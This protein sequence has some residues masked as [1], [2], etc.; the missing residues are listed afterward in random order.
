MRIVDVATFKTLPAGTVFTSYNPDTLLGT[1]R[2]LEIKQ[3]SPESSMISSCSIT[4]IESLDSEGSGD[5]VDKI[6]VMEKEGFEFP[7]DLDAGMRMDIEPNERFVVYSRDDVN[8]L[9]DRLQLA[10]QGH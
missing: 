8:A 10:L 9:I 2:P 5:W 6:H 4:G 1:T 3:T 7:V